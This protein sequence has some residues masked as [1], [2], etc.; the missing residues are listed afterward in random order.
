MALLLKA[1]AYFWFIDH[2]LTGVVDF[3]YLYSTEF[4]SHLSIDFKKA[5]IL[6]FQ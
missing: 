2:S 6:T 3:S 4:H 1:I 5:F